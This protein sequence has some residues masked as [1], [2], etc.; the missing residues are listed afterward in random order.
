MNSNP[1]NIPEN[2]YFI[3]FAAFLFGIYMLHPMCAGPTVH[4]SWTA[5]IRKS[6]SVLGSFD[7]SPPLS[8]SAYSESRVPSL[9]SFTIIFFLIECS[10]IKKILRK[11]DRNREISLSAL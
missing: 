10:G 3:A 8:E 11:G 7:L 9:V 6:M 1:I 4:L 2:S 5:V